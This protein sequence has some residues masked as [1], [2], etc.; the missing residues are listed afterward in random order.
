MFTLESDDSEVSIYG[1][2]DV[3][4]CC[5]D[6]IDLSQSIKQPVLL[7]PMLLYVYT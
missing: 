2:I 6:S 1:M 4:S 3:V 7:L 5:T